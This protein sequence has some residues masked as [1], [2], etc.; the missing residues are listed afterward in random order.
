MHPEAVNVRTAVKV[1]NWDYGKK[2]EN[3]ENY[4]RLQVEMHTSSFFSLLS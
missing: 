4:D 1:A 3:S 2:D